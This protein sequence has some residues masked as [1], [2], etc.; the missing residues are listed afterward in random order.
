LL[1]CF[2][3][4]V[5]NLWKALSDWPMVVNMCKTKVLKRQMPKHF[6]RFVDINFTVLNLL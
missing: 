6:N 4:T 3:R 1:V 5:N 2:A